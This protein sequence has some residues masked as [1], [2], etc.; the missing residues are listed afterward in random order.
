M[1]ILHINTT[2]N[3]GGAGRAMYRLHQGLKHQGQA[4]YIL[5]KSRTTGEPDVQAIAE[6]VGNRHSLLGRLI[7][8]VGVRADAWF[9]I[10]DFHR[11]TRHIL[12]TKCFQQAQVVHF[13]NLHG[14]YFNYHLLPTFA[15]HKPV[16]WTLH[17]MWALTGHCAYSYDCER[18]KTGCFDCPLLREPGR[19]MVSPGPT[20]IDRTRRIW[21][22]KQQLYRKTRLHVV[23]PSYW[24]YKLAGESIL[25]KA[26]SIQCIPNGVDLAVFRPVDRTMARCALDIDLNAKVILFVAAHVTDRR[27]GFS[28]LLNALH[29]LQDTE[30]I[31]LLTTGTMGMAGTQLGRFRCRNLGQLSDERLLS[32]AYNAADL[33]VFP[34]LADN[35][36]LVLIESLAC[37]TPIVSFDVGG[38]PEM[39]RHGE[40]GYLACYKDAHDLAQGVLTLL[41]DDNLRARMR[42]QCREIAEKEYG[43]ALQAQRYIALYERAYEE[44]QQLVN[45]GPQ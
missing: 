44:H 19:Q 33:L 16:V 34:T 5:A 18:W 45:N 40:T 22:N 3:I 12:E 17:D 27:K 23:T 32:L 38:V 20:R 21:R 9:G 39:V 7:D 15:A 30:S 28:Y 41:E 29:T 4:S 2:D 14:G 24:L 6:A 8:F 43:L 10:P 26:D 1:N 42:Q 35:Q 11:S 31:V 37:G 36:P 25:A 13:H